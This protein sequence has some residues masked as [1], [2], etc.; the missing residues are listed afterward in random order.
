[1]SP[2]RGTSRRSDCARAKEWR[3]EGAYVSGSARASSSALQRERETIAVVQLRVLADS[4]SATPRWQCATT[5]AS[6]SHLASQRSHWQ[7]GRP[8]PLRART[9]VKDGRPDRGRS[10]GVGSLTTQV[11]SRCRRSRSGP[12]PGR[13][14]QCCPGTRGSPTASALGSSARA[15]PTLHSS[16]LDPASLTRLLRGGLLPLRRCT[17]LPPAEDYHLPLR[18]KARLGSAGLLFLACACEWASSRPPPSSSACAP[19]TQ[20]TVA[21]TAVARLPSPRASP[22]GRP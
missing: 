9:D 1:M 8:R 16:P 14:Q 4:V 21:K 17:A 6:E 15:F 7:P 12:C 10:A 19:L 20:R 18:G 2:S 11:R 13:G 3:G 22:R 5:R